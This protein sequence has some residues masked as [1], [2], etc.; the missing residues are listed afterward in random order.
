MYS[1]SQVLAHLGVVVSLL[2]SSQGNGQAP[3]TRNGVRST[4]E[5]N[6]GA[7]LARLGHDCVAFVADLS[8]D[9]FFSRLTSKQTPNGREYFD[10]TRRITKFPSELMVNVYMISWPCPNRTDADYER[11]EVLLQDLRWGIAWKT[12]MKTRQVEEFDV[13]LIPTS[14]S[15]FE[16]HF[17][18]EDLQ[19]PNPLAGPQNSKPTEYWR[20]TLAVHNQDACVTDSLILTATTNAGRLIERFSAHL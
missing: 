15:E 4:G 2:L 6:M 12:G 1:R 3:K 9:D 5:L 13:K 8:A 16:S 10:G 17:S 14:R 11:Q 20:L 18:L 19:L 7:G